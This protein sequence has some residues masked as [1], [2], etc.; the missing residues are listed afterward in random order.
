MRQLNKIKD[1]IISHLSRFVYVP[2]TEWIEQPV[3]R[4]SFILKSN[5]FSDTATARI[6]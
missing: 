3:R 2:F 5:T 6:S 4:P 1:L